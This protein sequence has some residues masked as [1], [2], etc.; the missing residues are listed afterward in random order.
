M[1]PHSDIF[2]RHGEHPTAV[3]IYPRWTATIIKTRSAPRPTRV[4]LTAQETTE[5]GRAQAYADRLDAP[6]QLLAGHGR[7]ARA[8]H[9]EGREFDP[10]S[11]PHTALLG[12][13][14]EHLVVSPL[15]SV[16][17]RL[18]RGVQPLAPAHEHVGALAHARV[19]KGMATLNTFSQ[20]WNPLD[21]RTPTTG[22][23]SGNSFDH[24]V[25]RPFDY[26]ATDLETAARL[27]STY[28]FDDV[29]YPSNH[30]ALGASYDLMLRPI[31]WTLLKA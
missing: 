1:R 7:C 11:S 23:W 25:H 5:A 10:K 21:S 18:A 12:S 17:R 31:G 29:G 14:C 30:R 6:S 8:L 27:T 26:I 22:T 9:I 2:A 16:C 15:S 20:W 3:L 4:T 24:L 19:V 13:R 28:S